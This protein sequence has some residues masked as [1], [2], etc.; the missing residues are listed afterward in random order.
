MGLRRDVIRFRRSRKRPRGWNNPRGV[1]LARAARFAVPALA[2]AAVCV[3]VLLLRI[4]RPATPT[5]G[6][7]PGPTAEPAPGR[8]DGAP[9]GVVIEATEEPAR[10][11]IGDGDETSVTR[12]GS[13]EE[14][15]RLFWQMIDG[16]EETARLEALSLPDGVL[17]EAM[18]KFSNYFEA[19]SVSPDG[20]GFTVA[21]KTGVK[22]LS[23]IRQGRED[24]LDDAE[25]SM[26][27]KAREI[28]GGLVFEGMTDVEKELA[29][30]DYVA[31]HCVYLL[32]ADSGLTNSA[33]GFFE[34]GR[35][36]CAGYV[37]AFR[38]L[39]GLA[40][41]EVEMIGGPTTR[42]RPGSKGHAWNLVRL[43]G[44]WYAVD[45]TW[46]DGDDSGGALEHTFFNLPCSA[47][48][49]SRSWDESCCPGGVYAASVDDKYYYNRP[50]FAARSEGEALDLARRQV[51]ADGRAYVWFRNGGD[52]GAV[53]AALGGYR[54][55]ELSQDLEID[56]YKFYP[57]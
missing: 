9:D 6:P 54:A 24:A 30:H 26:A 27:R 5:P 25:R 16:G 49:S 19:Y 44:V 10:V 56:L 12:V 15:I 32:D 53:A 47:F 20:L 23:A 36:Q 13:R 45:V 46:D 50:G 14:L 31:D 18:D 28:V 38:L 7:T 17:A 1:L 4:P 29:I 33:R 8:P 35:C 22:L 40:G 2:L 41:L 34:G 21:L 51:E 3:A 48:G 55:E 11:V 39:A 37:D 52:G 57:Q 43:D 42:D